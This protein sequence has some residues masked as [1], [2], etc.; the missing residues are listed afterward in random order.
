MLRPLITIVVIVLQRLHLHLH[1]L[2]HPIMTIKTNLFII[3]KLIHPKRM[4][5]LELIPMIHQNDA[6][7][8]ITQTMSMIDP[9]QNRL[10]IHKPNQ[11]KL[12][13]LTFQS[14][15]NN[16]PSTQVNQNGMT[17]KRQLT[18]CKHHPKL[19]FKPRKRKR[20]VQ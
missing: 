16:R 12:Y 9:Q 3:Q 8:W 5:I 20:L 6:I 1:V 10:M 18:R 14:H 2:N 13:L 15:Q 11:L 19:V 4:Q 7:D 17:M